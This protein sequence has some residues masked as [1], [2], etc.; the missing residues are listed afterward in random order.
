MAMLHESPARAGLVADGALNERVSHH[1]G[2][3]QQT[4]GPRLAVVVLRG[5]EQHVAYPGGAA[6]AAVIVPEPRAKSSGDTG[7]QDRVQASSPQR[8]Q[9][10]PGHL[11]H[12]GVRQG[13]EQ[14]RSSGR[15]MAPGVG[16]WLTSRLEYGRVCGTTNPSS[17]SEPTANRCCAPWRAAVTKSA[18]PRTCPAMASAVATP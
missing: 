14:Q 17:S 7:G 11:V 12:S 6:A 9:V 18:R 8:C 5:I 10:K 16:H 13:G 15:P 1:A 3:L 2:R 4:G